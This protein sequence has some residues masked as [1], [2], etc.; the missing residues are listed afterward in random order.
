MREDL[1][2]QPPGPRDRLDAAAG[3]IRSRPFSHIAADCRGRALC[4]AASWSQ[5]FVCGRAGPVSGPLGFAPPAIADT[6]TVRP[7]AGRRG[8]S[9]ACA[10]P[11]AAINRV[12]KDDSIIAT[13]SAPIARVVA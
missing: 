8:A 10:P 7:R 2:Q 11:A 4:A 5:R 3:R 9:R 1:E 12:L 6:P 13:T